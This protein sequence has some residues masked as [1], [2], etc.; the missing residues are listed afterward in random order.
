VLLPLLAFLMAV[1]QAPPAPAH[2]DEIRSKI[3][4]GY[5]DGVIEGRVTSGRLQCERE[6]NITIFL[7]D[8]FIGQRTTADN[9]TWQMRRPNADGLVHAVATR[10]DFGGPGHDHRCKARRSVSIEVGPI[11]PE[12]TVLADDGNYDVVDRPDPCP[13]LNQSGWTLDD[14]VEIGDFAVGTTEYQAGGTTGTAWQARVWAQGGGSGEWVS[15][16]EV[17]DAV[18][19]QY[20]DMDVLARNL[21]DGPEKELIF[22]YRIGGS[23]SFLAYEV[24]K[25][26]GGSGPEVKVHRGAF[27]GGSVDVK[28]S[29]ID[30]YYPLFSANCPAPCSPR[31]WIRSTVDF[32][33]G[34]YRIIAVKEVENAVPSDLG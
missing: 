20:S 14:C 23:G 5:V 19:G 22:G 10:K 2:T 30:D 31:S 6:R 9:G 15:Y 33:N 32:A 3:V 25:I 4:I 24:V 11:P 28:P 7:N 17:V 13:G 27:E 34:A 21:G 18:G 12:T 16:L 29:S 26:F 8:G 1:G